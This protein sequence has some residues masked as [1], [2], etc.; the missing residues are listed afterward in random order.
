M[1]DT[2]NTGL[3]PRGNLPTLRLFIG[4]GAVELRAIALAASR[5]TIGRRP[6]NDVPLDDLTV[7]GEHAMIRVRNGDCVIHDLNSR[8]GTLVNGLPIQ[9]RVLV[10]GDVIDIGI[11]RIRFEAVADGARTSAAASGVRTDLAHADGDA[12]ELG[13]PA[14]AGA[15]RPGAASDPGPVPS[16]AGLAARSGGD[17]APLLPA[18]VEHLSGARTGQAQALDRAIN[19]VVGPAE[20]VAVIARRK[21]G[22]YITHL[23]GL[24]F[25]QLNGELIGLGAQRLADGDLIELAGLMLRFRVGP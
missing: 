23:E 12:A 14:L 24:T 11:Y 19:R 21:G 7:S 15:T 20:Q 5:L 17:F 6:Y 25:P 2:E 13:G 9:Q 16:Q 4:G 22:Y 1:P 3:P 18:R 10:D 8:N